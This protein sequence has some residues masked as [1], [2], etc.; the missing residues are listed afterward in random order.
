MSAIALASGLI[1]HRLKPPLGQT[2]DSTLYVT[3]LL[4]AW[5]YDIQDKKER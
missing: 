2:K 5:Q 4:V 1:A 3:F